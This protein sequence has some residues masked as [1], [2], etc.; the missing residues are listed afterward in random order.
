M[1]TTV[2]R[3]RPRTLH[4]LHAIL[5]A[6]PVPLFLGSLLSDIA[7]SKSYQ[8]Q[9]TNFSSWLIAGGLVFGGFAL[10]WALIGLLRADRRAGRPLV[11]FLLLLATWGLGFVNA[12]T[13]ARDAWAIMPAGLILSA[14]VA[15][16][17]GVGAWVGF[18]GFGLGERR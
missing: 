6:A 16:L 5:L 9:W 10:L 8:V 14:L 15:A 17:A 2:D 11:G 13:H 3:A 18:S 12:L 7:Y 1:A 4:P